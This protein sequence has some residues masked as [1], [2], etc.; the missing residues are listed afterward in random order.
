MS[1]RA[2]RPG[3]LCLA[4]LAVCALSLASCLQGEVRITVEPDGSGVIEERLVV[5]KMFVLGQFQGED[6]HERDSVPWEETS[7]IFATSY[8]NSA[9]GRYLGPIELVELELEYE[10]AWIGYHARFEFADINMLQVTG[11]PS[12]DPAR[13]QDRFP[14]PLTFVHEQASDGT[15]TLGLGGG[16][17]HLLGTFEAEDQDMLNAEAIEELLS[18][19]GEALVLA[20]HLSM[21]GGYL[22]EVVPNGLP[23]ANDSASWSES[24]VLID[25]DF[26][27]FLD[28]IGT[29]TELAQIEDPNEQMQSTLRFLGVREPQ[30]PVRYR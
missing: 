13:E 23:V 17:A 27:Q 30:T 10:G 26:E 6:P 15:A 29:L 16:F 25:L 5:N 2:V 14:V 18:S 3:R 20:E 8:L 28:Q 12:P 19:L 1:M 22:F 21:E 24:I 4:V 7:W 9:T 11:F